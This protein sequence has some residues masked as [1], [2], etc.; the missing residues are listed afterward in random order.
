ME[1]RGARIGIQGFGKVGINL[2]RFASSSG[3]K[4]VAVSVLKGA[5]YAPDGLNIEKIFELVE[6]FG[7]DF[8]SHYNEGNQIHLEEFFEK[9]MDV[10]CPCAGIYPIHTE[11]IRKIKA[12]IIVPGCNVTATK[13]VERLLYNR[14]IVYL[15]GFVCNA[16]GVLGLA[17][18]FFGVEKNERSD[19]LDRGIQ[20]K[21][22]NIMI[23]AKN[24]KEAPAEIAH[25]I[26]K[27]NQER[28]IFGTKEKMNQKVN[29]SM[30]FL[31][32]TLVSKQFLKI[33]FYLARNK[34]LF[35]NFVINRYKKIVFERLFGR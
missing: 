27:N 17:L 12:K 13:E 8:V 20:K 18:R 32:N 26:V 4:L 33:L 10:I 31:R 35:P 29:P 30:G 25:R 24:S 34:L 15:P 7:D 16:G 1:L 22:R 23:Q 3:L 11:N 19:F 6:K 9:E 14:G 21:V 5:L 28:F 2:L